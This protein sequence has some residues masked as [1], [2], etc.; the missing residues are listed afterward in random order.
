M[1]SSGV[2]GRIQVA[3]STWERVHE[4]FAFEERTVDIKGMGPMTAY[5]LIGP[6]PLSAE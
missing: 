1:Q 3:Q 5:L 4:A 6:T 2:P